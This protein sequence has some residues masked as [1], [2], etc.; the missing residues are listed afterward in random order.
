MVLNNSIQHLLEIG[1]PVILLIWN[2]YLFPKIREQDTDFVGI[3]TLII[4]VILGFAPAM[5]A[6]FIMNM[7]SMYLKGRK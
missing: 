4:F 6:W 2:V 1:W 3:V 5:V 7:Y